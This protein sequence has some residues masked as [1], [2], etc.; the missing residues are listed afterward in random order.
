[1]IDWAADE[2]AVVRVG[3]RAFQLRQHVHAGRGPFARQA[4]DLLETE[5]GMKMQ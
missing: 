1:V 4:L 5:S 2:R 3:R